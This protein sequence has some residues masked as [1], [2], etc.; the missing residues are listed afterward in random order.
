MC[1]KSIFLIFSS[2]FVLTFMMV[3]TPRQVVAQCYFQG[4][5][6]NKYA[7]TGNKAIS[8]PQ[9]SIRTNRTPMRTD[10]NEVIQLADK[11][12][13][14]YPIAD[15]KHRA[16]AVVK[17][18][19]SYFGSGTLGHTWIII[20]NSSK[21]GD[22]TS[23]GYH[24]SYGFVKNGNSF[25]KNDSVERT[26]P[27]TSLKQRPEELEKIVIPALNRQS[28]EIANIMGIHA[29]A[30]QRGAYTPISNCAW[31]AGNLW[32]TVTGESLNF[33]QNFNGPLYAEN[34][35][36]NFLN[37]VFKIADPGLIAENIAEK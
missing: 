2:I 28:V 25:I 5:A 36:M 13:A 22:Y 31:F 37:N 26:V 32:N 19:T 16:E 24:E 12:A 35:G 15:K 9:I 23:Y 11:A 33:E 27:L 10:L 29:A 8:Y 18:L 6:D 34:W 20:F 21:P 17:E 3:A 30:P 4:I 7:P 1:K 14:K